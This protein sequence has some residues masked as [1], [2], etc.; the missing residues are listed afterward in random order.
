M[1]L[2]SLKNNY[3]LLR[4]YT[5]CCIAKGLMKFSQ[6]RVA[7]TNGYV[8][9]LLGR[10]RAVPDILSNDSEKR[11][12][13]ER[14]VV[15]TIIQG[16]ASDIIKLAMIEVDVKMT[17]NFS[18]SRLLMQVHDEL[19]FEVDKCEDIPGFIDQLKH[20]M[21]VVVARRLRIIDVPLV[22]N[23]KIGDTWGTLMEF[24]SGEPPAA[25]TNP[26]P[27]D[28]TNAIVDPLSRPRTFFKRRSVD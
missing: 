11:S 3:F 23:V 8:R 25:P 4:N 12:Y 26:G 14:Q 13:A 7:R 5:Q 24:Q 16:T 9:T 15:N 28:L 2:S 17:C 20:G 21:E 18:G 1:T 6:C 19:I 27:N 10:T 22:V